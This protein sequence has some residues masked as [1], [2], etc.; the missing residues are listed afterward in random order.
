V[1]YVVLHQEVYD[2]RKCL[3]VD[4]DFDGLKNNIELIFGTNPYDADTDNDGVTDGAEPFWNIDTDGDG[5]WVSHPLLPSVYYNTGI[6]ALDQDS[7]GDGVTDGV[8]MGITDLHNHSDEDVLPLDE[9]EEPPDIYES[10][11]WIQGIPD[12][13]ID[14]DPTTTT[15]PLNFDTDGDGLPD[16]FITDWNCSQDGDGSLNWTVTTD[17]DYTGWG[18]YQKWQG[19]DFIPDGEWKSTSGETDATQV[20]TDRDGIPDGYERVFNTTGWI[21]GKEGCEGKIELPSEGDIANFKPLNPLSS[22]TDGDGLVDALEIS[23]PEALVNDVDYSIYFEVDKD[24][25]S[26]TNPCHTDTDFDGI[27][28]SN[29]DE[30]FNGR[31]DYG[32]TNASHPDT[33]GDHLLDGA[34]QDQNGT[35][36]WLLYDFDIFIFEPEYYPDWDWSSSSWAEFDDGGTPEDPGDDTWY[37]IGEVNVQTDA[38]TSDTDGDGLYDGNN[39]GTDIKGELVIH[40]KK[41]DAKLQLDEPLA[42]TFPIAAAVTNQEEPTDPNDDDTDGD[43]LTDSMEVWGWDVTIIYEKDKK[44]HSERWVMSNPLVKD[45][46]GDTVDDYYE[47][48]NFS[49][50]LRIDTDGDKIVDNKEN[51]G[52]LTQIEG[53]N[54][55]VVGDIKAKV[56]VQWDG[57]TPDMKVEVTVVFKDNAGLSLVGIKISGK[58]WKTLSLGEGIN[59]YEFTAEF[60][61]DYWKLLTSGWDI[62]VKCIDVNG[63]GV[64]GSTHLD[65]ILEGIVKVILAFLKALW[66]AVK[67]L[68]S[69]LFTWIWE[70]IKSLFNN[71]FKPIIDLFKRFQQAIIEFVINLMESSAGTTESSNPM[72]LMGDSFD[73]SFLEDFDQF[74]KALEIIYSFITVVYILIT[75]IGYLLLVT[76][77]GPLADFAFGYFAAIMIGICVEV[78]LFALTEKGIE[79]VFDYVGE[80]CKSSSFAAIDFVFAVFAAIAALKMSK[81]LTGKGIPEE[82]EKNGVWMSICAIFISGVSLTMGSWGPAIGIDEDLVPIYSLLLGLLSM[83]LAFWGLLTTIKTKTIGDGLKSP[84]HWWEE[85]TSGIGLTIAVF[86]FILTAGEMDISIKLEDVQDQDSTD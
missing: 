27:W 72:M 46:D 41:N 58:S 22:N 25:N 81:V 32:E 34:N 52:N 10:L 65:G 4:S 39:I 69:K 9:D 49:D 6:N 47:Y 30:N 80:S 68:A 45:T 56:T 44:T 7:D 38:T 71:V 2:G 23:W 54:P 43:E 73:L 60:G 50:P 63:N 33:D 53:Q 12:Y 36:D 66:E 57:L 8:E 77:A 84:L 86:G 59:K 85:V 18:S 24:P 21:P 76:P 48:M 40:F 29:E 28:D 11:Q 51:I 20:D 75:A 13:Q 64:T 55:E 35:N 62:D 83:G 5:D 15:D 74:K 14:V 70:F 16:G 61:A 26:K 3:N 1:N 17:A 79:Q 19:E 42:S 82:K 67:E 31:H 37:F 78:I